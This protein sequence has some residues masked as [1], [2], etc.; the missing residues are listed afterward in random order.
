QFES[1]LLTAIPG[2][3]IIGAP[4]QRL[5]N[6]VMLL[7]PRH[8]NTRWVAAL[9]KRGFQISTGSACATGRDGPSHVL[10]AMGISADDARRA[11]R[12]SA[13]WETMPAD[14]HALAAAF[15]DALKY[16]DSES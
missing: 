5:W 1:M 8:A 10:A 3:K 15:A 13:G 6:T 7:P 4:A 11:L 14:L 12:L 2:A 9:D 16:L